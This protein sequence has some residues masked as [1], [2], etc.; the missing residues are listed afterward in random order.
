MAMTGQELR[1]WRRKWGLT[2]EELARHLG[3]IGLTVARWETKA[4][5]IPSF[6]PLALR[7]LENRLKEEAPKR[8]RRVPMMSIP[9]NITNDH[10]RQAAAQI[11]KQGVPIREES[12]K[13]N[14]IVNDKPYPP[15]H[16]VRKA[17]GIATGYEPRPNELRAGQ[18]LPL[19]ERLGFRII[20][21]GES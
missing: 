16:I 5:T 14:V 12:K 6:L 7:G 9:R 18:A 4:R 1:E 17:C 11:D 8:H 13:Y 10:I 19:L 21:K 2:Q 15:P 20:P 3:V